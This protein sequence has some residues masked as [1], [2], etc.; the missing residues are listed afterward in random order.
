MRITCKAD[1][2]GGQGV[3]GKKGGTSRKRKIDEDG[4]EAMPKKR[5]KKKVQVQVDAETETDKGDGGQ[6]KDEEI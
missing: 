4:A 6:V 5:G 1:L 3:E 2:E